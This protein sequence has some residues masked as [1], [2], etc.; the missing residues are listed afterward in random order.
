MVRIAVIDKEKCKPAI[1]G[2]EC[3]KCCP[4]EKKEADSCIIIGDSAKI[5][6]K[7]CIGCGICEKRCPFSAIKIINLPAIDDD[8]IIHRYG[9]NGFAL[10][11]L[12]S[13]KKGSVL[14][15]LGRNGIGK[16][17]AVKIL[18][19]QEKLNLGK[20]AATEKELKDFFQG[21]EL[22]TYFQK[23][24]GKTVAY[25][26]QNLSSLSKDIKAIDLLK[27]RGDEKQIMKFAESLNVSQVL[28]NKLNKLSGGE[29]QRI[30]IIAASL[31]EADI[32]FYDEPLAYL[33]IGERLR[34][35]DFIKEVAKEKTIVVVEHDLL[36]LDYLTDY[37][38]IFFGEQG[39]FGVVSTP[40]TSREGVNAYLSGFLKDENM[41]IRDKELKFNFTKNAPNS[42][43][44]ISEWDDFS[45][46][47][48]SGFNLE[49]KKGEIH[50][51]HVIGILGRNGTGKTTFVRALAGELEVEQEGVKKKLDLNLDVSYKPQYLFT[52]S[53]ET[54]RDIIFKEKI[55]KKVS[56]QFNLGVLQNKKLKDLSGGELQRFS[57]ARCLAKKA[58]VYLIDEPSAYL[59]V[60]ER[61]NVAKAIKDLMVEKEKTAFV[62]DH[63]LLLVSYLADSVINFGGESGKSG[64]AGEVVGFEKGITNLLE[65][66][67]ITLRK[68]KESG[69]P[70]IN[71]KGSVKDREQKSK[72]HLVEL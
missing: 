53:E 27:E 11:G 41:R 49:V 72:G 14:G 68:E 67:D 38:S 28:D 22:L 17:T 26:P 12:P 16:T 57:I 15:M 65:S 39:A 4:I 32:Y 34:V 64:I 60:E 10:Y 47:F 8:S 66:L 45:V 58:D 54:V 70:R 43:L 19:G 50:Q 71:K 29:L 56:S 36:I 5:D 61:I 35:S 40:K 3:K 33:D 20:E 62:I 30:A 44:K 24:G 51:N 18:A 23:L 21:Q 9:N 55:G 63:D 37:L 2:H 46:S 13:P 1:C 6:E 52:E 25:K 42:G 7:T 59:D 31:G 69:R 48:D